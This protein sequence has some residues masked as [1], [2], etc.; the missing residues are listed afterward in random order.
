MSRPQLEDELERRGEPAAPE[1]TLSDLED[2][3]VE[4]LVRERANAGS[5]AGGPEAA[6]GPEP[7]GALPRFDLHSA[8]HMLLTQPTPR[9]R[10]AVIAGG[11]SGEAA[12]SLESART[13]LDMLRTRPHAEQAAQLG[14]AL[15]MVRS[16]QPG[17]EKIVQLMECFLKANS[18]HNPYL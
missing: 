5:D 13:V 2:R 18:P 4:H 15:M 10:V 9:L 16:P 14:M 8:T 12:V 1:A 7:A 11:P 17:V 6:G 3:L